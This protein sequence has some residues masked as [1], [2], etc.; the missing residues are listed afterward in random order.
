MLLLNLVM[1]SKVKYPLFILFTFSVLKAHLQTD[2]LTYTNIDQ[3]LFGTWKLVRIMEHC[4]PYFDDPGENIEKIGCY[5]SFL[6]NG[7]FIEINPKTKQVDSG[8]WSA[9]IPEGS[10][11]QLEMLKLR[12]A[13][14]QDSSST[15]V[16]MEVYSYE[17]GPLYTYSKHKF[18]VVRRCFWTDGQSNVYVYKRRKIK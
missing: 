12:I 15:E 1:N 13:E 14:I 5:Y 17:R 2:T 10:D 16:K 6:E 8:V 11:A 7:T 3:N 9:F 4:T 18:A